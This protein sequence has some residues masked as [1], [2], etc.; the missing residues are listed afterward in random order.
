[1]S[2]ARTTAQ[3]LQN[4]PYGKPSG[5][6]T[7]AMELRK[8]H[9]HNAWR[10]QMKWDRIEANWKDL[11][12]LAKEKWSKLTN[13]KFDTIAGKRDQ[14]IDWLQAQYGISK[15]EAELEVKEWEEVVHGRG[16]H[17]RN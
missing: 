3:R 8:M 4:R 6:F 10:A 13:G 7:R 17:P 12:E 14:L 15:A 16:R 5:D 9:T 11:R 1:M 2:D